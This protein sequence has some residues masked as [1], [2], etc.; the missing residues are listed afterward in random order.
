MLHEN[1]WRIIKKY[2][3]WMTS[4]NLTVL[5]Q[6]KNT[7]N[8]ATANE[9]CAC[10]HLNVLTTWTLSKNSAYIEQTKQT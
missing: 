3:L 6:R 1:I 7:V 2:I 9:V 8:K 4:L 5:D 10:V